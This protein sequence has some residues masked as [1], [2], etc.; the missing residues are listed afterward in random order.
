MTRLF[1]EI[2]SSDYQS[3]SVPVTPGIAVPLPDVVVEL[4]S[5]VNRN[6]PH[7]MNHLYMDRDKIF[8]LYDVVRIVVARRNWRDA[9]V[10]YAPIP[11]RSI[12]P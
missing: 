11:V 12:Q 1:A 4:G 6:N 3:I 7:V 5:T 2:R 9:M 10:G 8:I